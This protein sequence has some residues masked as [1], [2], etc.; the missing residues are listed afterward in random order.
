M[1]VRFAT[2]G[3]RPLRGLAPGL[4]S[5]S[6]LAFLLPALPA[7]LKYIRININVNKNNV[8]RSTA[9]LTGENHSQ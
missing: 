6:F 5:F 1:K 4:L 3:V 8:E 9:G 2:A 7:E